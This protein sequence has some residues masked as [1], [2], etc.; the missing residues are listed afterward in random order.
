MVNEKEHL[1]ALCNDFKYAD[2]IIQ[3]VKSIT[4]D[5]VVPAISQLRYAGWHLAGW[6]KSYIAGT[7]DENEFL[8]VTEHS[9]RAIFEAARYGIFFCMTGIRDFRNMYSG[10]IMPG[11]IT[12]F[13]EKMKNAEE[14]RKFVISASKQERDVRAK[15]CYD[16]FIVI[17]N[18]LQELISCQPELNQLKEQKQNEME[19]LKNRHKQ[20]ITIAVTSAIVAIAGVVIIVLLHFF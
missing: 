17:K 19:I 14:A 20:Q 12:N 6:L 3:D 10:E 16:Y 8:K 11:I 15:A 5:E 7:P 2:E 18:I 13:S 4:N 9:K 1:E